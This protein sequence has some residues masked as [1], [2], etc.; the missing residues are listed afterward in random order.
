M[1]IF[2]Y[3]CLWSKLVSIKALGAFS[4]IPFSFLTKYSKFS[5]ALAFILLGVGVQFTVCYKNV[6]STWSLQQQQPLEQPENFDFYQDTS[7]HQEISSGRS[8]IKSKNATSRDYSSLTN[9]SS[10]SGYSIP[11]PGGFVAYHR[12][13]HNTSWAITIPLFT[14]LLPTANVNDPLNVGNQ[15]TFQVYHFTP[16]FYITFK[17]TLGYFFTFFI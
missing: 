4:G 2:F 3:T 13:I 14:F 15:V 9:P 7:Q 8:S 11:K 17:P 10:S 12:S 5:Y 1:K 6:D 16:T